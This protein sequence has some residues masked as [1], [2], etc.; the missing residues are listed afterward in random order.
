[1]SGRVMGMA[2]KKDSLEIVI[3][4]AHLVGGFKVHSV[5]SEPSYQKCIDIVILTQWQWQHA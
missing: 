3:E 1:M 2:V 5:W 4:Q